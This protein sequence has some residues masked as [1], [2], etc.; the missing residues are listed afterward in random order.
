MIQVSE[1]KPIRPV[2]ILSRH[3]TDLRDL[4]PWLEKEWILLEGFDNWHTLLEAAVPEAVFVLDLEA[5]AIPLSDAIDRLQARI[6]SFPSFFCILK[7]SGIAHRLEAVRA[8]AQACFFRPWVPEELANPLIE[9]CVVDQMNPQR[10]LLLQQEPQEIQALLQSA[11]IETRG[12]KAL[13][14]LLHN[15][16]DFQ[17]DLLIL[18]ER[19]PQANGLEITAVVR[20]H[21]D[22]FSL[23]ILLLADRD[24]EIQSYQAKKMGV[25]E[26]FPQGGDPQDL[27]A[28]VQQCIRHVRSIYSRPS[29]RWEYCKTGLHNHRYLLRQLERTLQEPAPRNIGLIYFQVFP[30]V[31][32]AEQSK[33]LAQ[34]AFLLEIGHLIRKHL[35]PADL[36]AQVGSRD[37]A[38]LGHREDARDFMTWCE[39]LYQAFSEQVLLIEGQPLRIDA[40][41]GILIPERAAEDG[42]S[43]MN[44][45]RRICIQAD[46]EELT[47]PIKMHA[48]PEQDVKNAEREQAILRLLRETLKK[49]AF[50][51]LFQPIA[52]TG[53]QHQEHYDTLLRIRLKNGKSLRPDFF[54]PVAEKH[55]LMAQIDRWVLSKSLQV[56]AERSSRSAPTR[57]IVRQ[58]LETLQ[59]QDWLPWLQQQLA[60]QELGKN[61]PILEFQL[62]DLLRHLPVAK[63]RFQE[64]QQEG[65]D[66]CIG[67]YTDQPAARTL[68]TELPIAFIKPDASLLHPAGESKDPRLDLLIL[69]AH[70]NGVQVIAGQLEAFEA[71]TQAWQSKV[72]YVLGYF[73]QP[74]LENLDFDFTESSY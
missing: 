18:D 37:F 71:V 7:E 12:L 28:M 45:A 4:K 36:A 52:A 17:P 46:Q 73:L 43:L 49:N 40:Y 39:Q 14:E 23:P 64:L 10:V 38:L 57:L 70:N 55:G 74:P 44:Q 51:L 53:E 54:L 68:L 11:G 9:R 72:D 29:G 26:F 42:E 30:Q 19:L 24:T 60:A 47:P 63:Q 35:H 50:R 34:D 21:E 3:D 58:N 61:K 59:A 2:Q 41:F 13:K 69:H 20:T 27:L 62:K 67:H 5:L 25:D 32:E 22:F 15:L 1:A 66:L 33:I 31:P 8:G 16:Y 65:I 48:S 56:L 6:G